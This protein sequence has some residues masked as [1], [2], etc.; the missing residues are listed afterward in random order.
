M[1]RQAF[2]FLLCVSLLAA[3]AAGCGGPD[4]SEGAPQAKTD[5]AETPAP[6]A[7]PE[8][9]RSVAGVAKA[10]PAQD[11]P[12]VEEGADGTAAAP[13]DGAPVVASGELVSPV[14]SEVAV[15]LPGRVGR[16]YVDEGARVR[17]GQPLLTLETQYLSLELKQAQAE[18]ARARAAAAEAE[19]DF[20]RKAE[21]V[22]KDSV[23]RAAYD[24]SQSSHQSALAAV[25]GAEASE[26]LARQRLA[27][28]VL[29]SPITGVVAEKRTDVGERLGDSS[30]AFVIVQT[31]PIKL[32]FRLPERYLSSVRRGQSVRAMVDAYPGEVFEGRVSL[33][34]GVV[35]SSTR[36]VAVE[37]EL[38]NRDGRLSP[39]MF[40]RVEIDA[41]GR[42]SS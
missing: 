2:P 13:A 27:D 8:D 19:R 32:R 15:R 1:K 34:A 39:G 22:A 42:S 38:P 41:A 37:T 3:L 29:H 35:D 33:V 40:A 10:Q 26:D 31:S 9:V 12:V 18:V 11:A 28:A 4:K 20:K 5:G 30:V 23:S 7:L 17:K 25:A 14:S 16:M 6:P 24:R 21:L 36:T